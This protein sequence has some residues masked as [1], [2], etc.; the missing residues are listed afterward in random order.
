MDKK[1]VYTQ[2]GK[3]IARVRKEKGYTQESFAEFTDKSWS[4]IAKMETGRQN[5]SIGK[6]VDI[7]D[8]LGVDFRE[9]LKF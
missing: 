5:V 1:F 7:A 6:L 3:N 8:Y 9:F 4:S 2:I